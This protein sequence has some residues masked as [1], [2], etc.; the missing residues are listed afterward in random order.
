VKPR[1]LDVAEERDQCVGSMYLGINV[2]L[3]D[4]DAGLA[5]EDLMAEA[6]EQAHEAAK[7]VLREHPMFLVEADYS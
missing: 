5:Q 4:V 3:A 1:D 7:R 2:A 6:F